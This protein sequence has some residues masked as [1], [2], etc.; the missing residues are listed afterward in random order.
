MIYSESLF[1]V[2]HFWRTDRKSFYFRCCK[3]TQ[4][5]NCFYILGSNELSQS[6]CPKE[7]RETGKTSQ[8]FIFSICKGLSNWISW[9]KLNYNKIYIDTPIPQRMDIRAFTTKFESW[10]ICLA[11]ARSTVQYFYYCP[12]STIF[13]AVFSFTSK[14]KCVKVWINQS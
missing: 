2:R 6:S 13:P 1:Y 8:S 7:I 9:F 12:I 14:I 5:A 3:G 11:Q 10:C 4:I